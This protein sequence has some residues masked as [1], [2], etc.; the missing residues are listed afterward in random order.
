[1]AWRHRRI[2]G[3]FPVGWLYGQHSASISHMLPVG[4]D[5]QAF[6]P[7]AP[8]EGEILGDRGAHCKV[9]GLSAVN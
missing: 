7:D 2:L 5:L 8:W 4:P 6:R 1:M 9:W 3:L